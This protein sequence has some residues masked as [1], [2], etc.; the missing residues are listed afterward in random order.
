MLHPLLSNQFTAVEV[1]HT[2]VFHCAY[3]QLQSSISDILPEG[4]SRQFYNREQESS[5][6]RAL[7]KV[8]EVLVKVI[9]RVFV[10]IMKT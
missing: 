9:E 2:E 4:R 6:L 3:S 1:S 10:D 7:A 8:V 5:N